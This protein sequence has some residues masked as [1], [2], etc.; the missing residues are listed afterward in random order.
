MQPDAKDN[1][2]KIVFLPRNILTDKTGNEESHY[3]QTTTTMINRSES[4][5]EQSQKLQ[6]QVQR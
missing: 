1:P 2:G 5:T 6:L 4:N 3:N